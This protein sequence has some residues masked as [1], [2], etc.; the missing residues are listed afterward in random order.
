MTRVQLA[1]TMLTCGLLIARRLA[2][3]ALTRLVY[4]GSGCFTGIGRNAAVTS[5]E[6]TAGQCVA[7]YDSNP[8]LHHRARFIID[9]YTGILVFFSNNAYQR[10]Y[11]QDLFNKINTDN[12]SYCLLGLSGQADSDIN[13]FSL[14][15]ELNDVWLQF[16]HLLFAQLVGFES[17]L[18]RGLG[19][20]NSYP[21]IEINS[22]VRGGNKVTGSKPAYWLEKP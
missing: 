13:M 14:N 8:G 18:M 2:K 20:D 21:A 10:Q 1:Q 5:L 22:I 12:H 6:L 7:T 3:P 11:D 9:N 15:T 16:P 17:S 19:S 4:A